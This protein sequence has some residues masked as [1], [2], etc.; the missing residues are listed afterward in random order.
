VT[1][2]FISAQAEDIKVKMEIGLSEL[3]ALVYV[4][5]NARGFG[6]VVRTTRPMLASV[7][8]YDRSGMMEPIRY[9]D[10]LLPDLSATLQGIV[11]QAERT[12]G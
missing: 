6:R 9:R 3:S 11:R 12:Y 1:A 8:D 4:L 7:Y 10:V 5:E 2:K